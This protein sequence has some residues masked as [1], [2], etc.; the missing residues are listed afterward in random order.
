MLLNPTIVAVN[1]LDVREWK[2]ADLSV[3]L[4]LPLTVDGH[5]GHLDDVADVQAQRGLVVRVGDAGLLHAG[6]RGELALEKKM[7]DGVC[8]NNLY[9]SRLLYFHSILH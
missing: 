6:V 3:E 7:F 1:E 8:L 2:M 9:M 5:L 4:A